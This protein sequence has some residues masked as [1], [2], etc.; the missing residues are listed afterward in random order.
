MWLDQLTR[1]I[2]ESK[3]VPIILSYIEDLHKLALFPA[4]QM[5]RSKRDD[6]QTSSQQGYAR[7][8]KNVINHNFVFPFGIFIAY[9]AP[10][11][12]QRSKKSKVSCG[13][14]WEIWAYYKTNIRWW[15][16]R[17]TVNLAHLS[18]HKNAKQ[19]LNISQNKNIKHKIHAQS[20]SSIRRINIRKTKTLF[21][22]RIGWLDGWLARAAGWLLNGCWTL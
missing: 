6:S 17:N 19:S 3:Y 12:K 14:H 11:S 7:M 5:T 2:Y 15:D 21:L 18:Y 10:W 9:S 16:G 22:I 1:F 4:N 13:V 8:C 20:L